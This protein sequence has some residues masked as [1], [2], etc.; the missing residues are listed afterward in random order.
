MRMVVAAAAGLMLLSACGSES[1]PGGSGSG[2]G[3]G[4]GSGSLDGKTFLSV[5]VTEDGKPKEL[6]PNT[7]LQLQFRGGDVLAAAGCNSLG[8]QVSTTDGKL[9]V[10]AI[11]G[12]ELG[13][14]PARH[15]QD[16]WL[17][18]LLQ[19]RPAWK[20]DA[21][22][23]TLTRGGTT[24]VL[25]DKQTAQP[26]KALDGTRWTL[27]TVVSGRTASHTVGADRAHLT[28]G[29]ARITGS[30]GCNS[31]EG[32]VARTGNKVTI[33][34]LGMTLKGCSGDV[35]KLER[36]ILAV[37]QGELTYTIEADRLQLR[38]ADGNGLDFTAG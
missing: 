5:S 3:G 10:N 8:G 28:I 36:S 26:D 9:T 19:D 20:L 14:D 24:L 1:G 4:P 31:F 6:A 32:M 34:E 38:A 37:L 13:C 21:D 33:G 23:L 12:T 22:K 16:E 29:G 15:A 11:G 30:T 18:T 27:Q 2:P 17:S 7:R 25:Q 35:G